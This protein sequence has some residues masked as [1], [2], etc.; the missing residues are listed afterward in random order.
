MSRLFTNS[1]TLNVMRRE[2]RRISQRKAFYTLMILVPLVVFSF[3][4]YI[5]RDK[6]VID[7]PVGIVD[8]DN[9]ELSRTIVRAVESTR[10]MKIA[11][12]YSTVNEIKDGM[13]RGTIQGAFYIPDGL[14]KDIKNGKS[15]TIVVYKNSSN[16]I[17]GNLI[18]KDASTISQ[19]ISAGILIKRLEAKG[20]SPDRALE[21][22]NPIRVDSHSLYNPGYNYADF[23]PPGIVM[24]LLQML[25]MVLAVTVINEEI[26]EGT[27]TELFQTAGNR[28]SAVMFGKALAHTAI[29]T[30]TG[31]GVLGLLFPL[32]GITIKGSI[33]LAVP[34]MIFFIA[35]GFFPGFLVSCLVRNKFIATDI[36]AF[37]NSPAFLFSGYT[38]PLWAMPS[39]HYYY[40]QLLPFTHF[41][42][43]FLKIYRYNAPVMDLMPQL[44]A[45]SIF[46][47]IPM[48]IAALALK[49]RIKPLAL[50]GKATPEAIR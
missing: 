8:L 14:E 29:H 31:L 15:A 40:A 7:T 27:L 39:L 41:L 21:L 25:V 5:Y 26:D 38:F 48:V 18:L 34:F 37:Y 47:F 9:S 19:T 12:V 35:A 23:L 33:L 36:A 32:F 13:R 46:V 16:I 49:Y 28:V 4:F 17:I 11:E 2:F 20:L 3:M 43:G 1:P 50:T 44:A 10:S 42:T 30:A 45:L 22:A 6:V 24:V